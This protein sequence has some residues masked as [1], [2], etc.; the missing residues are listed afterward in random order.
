MSARNAAS[1]FGECL[2][3]ARRK[4][5]AVAN[6]DRPKGITVLAEDAADPRLA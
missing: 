2:D 5:S 3:P 6:N 1:Y 4:P